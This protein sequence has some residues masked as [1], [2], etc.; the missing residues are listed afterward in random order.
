MDA[1]DAHDANRMFRLAGDSLWSPATPTA[2]TTAH[3]APGTSYPQSLCV[4][5]AN[6]VPALGEILMGVESYI[7][8][9]YFLVDL[10]RS[11]PGWLID[12]LM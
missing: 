2:S 6:V 1:A 12:E 11:Y 5:E 9:L 3:S 7:L 4:E 10:F 8:F